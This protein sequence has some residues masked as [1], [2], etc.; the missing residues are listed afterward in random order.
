LLSKAQQGLI[1]LKKEA[2][3]LLIGGWVT[4]GIILPSGCMLATFQAEFS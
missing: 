2:E 4:F 1:I 3:N